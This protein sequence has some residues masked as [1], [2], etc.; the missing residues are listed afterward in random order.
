MKNRTVKIRKW[1]QR[2]WV[3]DCLITADRQTLSGRIDNHLVADSNGEMPPLNYGDIISFPDSEVID[4]FVD[5]KN[6]SHSYLMRFD[7]EYKAQFE[8]E[9]HEAK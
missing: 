5:E 2:F 7:K 9:F 6:S 1:D 4:W 8:K 3:K